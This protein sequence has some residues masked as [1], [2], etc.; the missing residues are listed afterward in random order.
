[1]PWTWHA[2]STAY[3]GTALRRPASRVVL[4]AALL[5]HAGAAGPRRADG[6]ARPGPA[7]GP[8]APVPRL[9]ATGTAL[10]VSSHVMDEATR[11]DRLLLLREGQL[12]A[13]ETPQGLLGPD[14]RG[15]RRACVPGADRGEGDSGMNRT[16]TLAPIEAKGVAA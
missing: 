1:M 15:R 9:A 10:L 13:D 11:C 8:V 16:L 14:R 3:V 12:L 5:G 2:T 6:R 4:A 7:P